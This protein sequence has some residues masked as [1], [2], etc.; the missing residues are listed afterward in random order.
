MLFQNVISLK[1]RDCYFVC[2]NMGPHLCNF[3]KGKGDVLLLFYFY[4]RLLFRVDKADQS[5]LIVRT[6]KG[7][8]FGAYMSNS[9]RERKD[10]R[11][12]SKS[13]YFGTAES[14]VFKV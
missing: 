12:R 5:L 11:E 2:Q 6:I 10:F 3:G 13:K 1:Y 8:I 9:W 4:R 14:Y 7:A